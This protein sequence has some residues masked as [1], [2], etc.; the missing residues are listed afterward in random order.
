MGASEDLQP[1]VQTRRASV[2]KL[3]ALLAAFVTMLSLS[4]WC[5]A[6]ETI[7][8]GSLD[9]ARR[10][11]REVVRPPGKDAPG[12]ENAAP[13]Q[14]LP[15][16]SLEALLTQAAKNNPMVKAA[17]HRW[18]AATHKRAQVVALPDP[19]VQAQ[20]FVHRVDDKL[21]LTAT[22]AIPYPGKLILAGREADQEAEAA[23]LRYE[24]AARDAFSE[25]KEVYFELYYIDR[26]QSVTDEIRKLYDRYAALAAGGLEPGQPKLPEAFRAE[27]QRAQLTYDLVLLRE[28]R[29]ASAEE[30]R[31]A[32]GAPPG[33]LIGRTED[34]ADPAALGPGVEEL[35]QAAEAHNQELLAAGVEIQRAGYQ[36]KLAHR[37]PIPD[38]TLGPTF[39]H[40][41]E[42]NEVGVMVGISIPLWAPKYKAIS[43][44]AGEL[45]EAAIAEQ[46]GQRL[47]VRADVA[48]AYFS[49]SNS[50]RLVQLYRDTLLP[51]AHQALQ[52]AEEL[53]RSQ[54]ANLSAVLETTA[55]VQNF[56]LAR[57]RATAD[58]Y[59]N[60]AR[61]E[62]ILGTAFRVQS[63]ADNA[64]ETKEAR[65]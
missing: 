53:Y 11:A 29:A 51:Q 52:S 58:F 54:Q 48:K 17:S 12:A 19:Q 14:A 55:T 28:M 64:L 63:A 7:E 3:I 8:S 43:R 27:S 56:E 20:Y 4:A 47:K 32:T 22:Q 46:Q 25:V 6:N 61:L 59:A 65:P 18:T 38:L 50:F 31:A 26:A 15:S 62:R 13:D 35:Q 2:S 39:M 9:E 41:S 10:S 30:L 24:A 34:V 49:L 23:R 36:L 33:T 1:S 57:L 40:R 42:G 60:V 16:A 37:A 45:N 5:L 21:W 44:E